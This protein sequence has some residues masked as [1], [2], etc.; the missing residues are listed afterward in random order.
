MYAR[1]INFIQKNIILYPHQFGFQKNKSTTLTITDICNKLVESIEKKHFSCCIFLDFAKAFDTVDHEILISKLEYYGI[2]GIALDWF[3]SYLKDRTQRVYV[4]GQLSDSLSITYGVPQGSVLGP[5]LFLL[6]IN[7][8]PQASKIIGFHLFADDTSLFFSHPNLNVIEDT[9][10]A[11][12]RKISDWLIANK[13]TLNTKKSNFLLV[14]PRQRKPSRKISISIDNEPLAET[15]HA[16]YLGVLMDN[17]LSWKYHIQQINIKVAK[18][19]GIIA[20]VRHFVSENTLIN[21][22]NAFISPHINYGITNWGGAYPKHLDPI[23]RKLKRAVRLIGF[24]KQNEHS[25]PLFKSYGLLNLDD[26][27]KLECAK[28]MY[29]VSN[30]KVEAHFQKLF[31][32]VNSRHNIQTRQATTGHLSQPLVRTNYKQNFITNYGVKVWNEIPREI[33]YT[34]SKKVFTKRYK[35]RLLDNYN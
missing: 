21:I 20:K 32:L 16:K 3:R 14:H 30:G 24:K 28:F 13:L 31:Q 11:E 8:I 25:A 35:T 10:N 7:D 19:L 6:Y 22:Y 4:G 1:L 15:D 27:Y 9:V 29:D 34:K 12:L 18:S 26:C 17:N 2:R 33:R 23:R 5:L